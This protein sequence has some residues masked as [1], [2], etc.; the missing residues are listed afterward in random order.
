[1]RARYEAGDDTE[2]IGSL[3]A[4]KFF[5]IDNLVPKMQENLESL[6]QKLDRIALDLEQHEA[7]VR[8]EVMSVGNRL[9][10][11]CKRCSVHATTEP[12]TLEMINDN[13][14]VY[15]YLAV[16]PDSLYLAYRSTYDDCFIS[17][18]NEDLYDIAYPAT[19]STEWLREASKP[20][21][22]KE[23]T[24]NLHRNI[25]D[26]INNSANI[27][28]HTR[29]VTTSGIMLIEQNVVDSCE[30]FEL[31]NVARVWGKAHRLIH[32]DPSAAITSASSLLETTFKHLLNK[33]G[34]EIPKDQNIKALYS[35]IKKK[36]LP[37]LLDGKEH[38]KI[39]GLLNSLTSAVECIGGIRTQIGDAHGKGPLQRSGSIEEAMLAVNAAGTISTF[40][41]NQVE[42]SKMA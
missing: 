28:K 38:E 25:S 7:E 41:I 1:M 20:E 24:E 5:N 31:P 18:G 32:S 33:L 2:T 40:L 8:R 34:I 6:F 15:G 13:L 21:R 3:L 29:K 19:W 23:L 16:G 11:V 9:T 17:P 35:E 4:L 30:K 22:I 12:F 10:E 36:L 26:L 27:V 39:R 37:L 14:D 42:K